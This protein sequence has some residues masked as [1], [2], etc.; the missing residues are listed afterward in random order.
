MTELDSSIVNVAIPSMMKDFQATT[1]QIQWV[2]TIYLLALGVVVPTSAWLGDYLGYK[3]LY[4]YSLGIFT[5]GSALCAFAGDETFL[6][7]A[8]VI[9]AIGG[10]MIPPTA[11]AMLYTLVPRDK[12]GMAMGCYLVQYINWRWI[13]TINLPIGIL[14]IFL[15]Y[16]ILP[17]FDKKDCGKFDF[18]GSITSAIAL[19]CLLFALSQGGDWGWGSEPTVI[20][21]FLSIMFFIIFTYHQLTSENPLLDL[22]VFKYGN[23]T[24]GNIM[25]I[26]ITIGLYGGVFFVPMY[27]QNIRGLGAFEAG[28]IM[29]PPALITGL[30]LPISGKIYDKFG[31]KVVVAVGVLCLALGTYL[32]TGI[33]FA[34]PTLTIIGWMTFRSLGMALCMMPIQTSLL[35]VIPDDKIGRASAI[36]NIVSRV[37]GS[38]GIACLTIL[39]NKRLAYHSTYHAWTTN[40]DPLNNLLTSKTISLSTALGMLQGSIFQISF[41]QSIRDMFLI[42]AGITLLAFIPAFILKKGKTNKSVITE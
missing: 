15:A 6:S 23:F 28:L 31:P 1:S 19:F 8:R 17:E 3:K 40:L 30:F 25:L 16:A 11:M 34:T 27:L 32:L 33:D 29:L 21:F 13:F 12:M 2:V 36:T 10:G 26:I 18:L 41:I 4:I 20:L 39:L 7:F 14:G 9:Q 42:T 38:F 22:R 24:I 37:A 35:S 5:I